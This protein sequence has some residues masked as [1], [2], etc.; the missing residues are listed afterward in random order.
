MKTILTLVT[1]IAACLAMA[2][3]EIVMEID[4]LGSTEEELLQKLREHLGDGDNA[5]VVITPEI[6]RVLEANKTGD[7]EVLRSV[8]ADIVGEERVWLPGDEEQ[9]PRHEHH[10]EFERFSTDEILAR[11]KPA[12]VDALAD[13]RH[14]LDNEQ[15]L[16]MVLEDLEGVE[17]DAAMEFIAKMEKPEP[18][19]SIMNDRVREELRESKARG[20]YDIPGPAMGSHLLREV[21]LLGTDGSDRLRRTS[22]EIGSLDEHIGIENSESFSFDFHGYE[23]MEVYPVTRFDAVLYVEK[24]AADAYQPHDPNLSILGHDGS[25]TTGRHSDGMWVTTV[26]AFD[27]RYLYQ[28]VLEKKLEGEERE[29]FVRMATDMIE[30]D[31]SR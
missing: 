15:D 20:W 31:L 2:Q 17:H 26:S 3:D 25:V 4:E 22:L 19:E 7:R 13:H 29:E 12:H 6:K 30:A 28:I 24:I 18:I 1:C 27:G 9:L 8:V 11:M 16:F 10:K 5:G 14:L 23:R 21:E